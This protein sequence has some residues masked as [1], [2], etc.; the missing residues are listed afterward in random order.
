MFS[1]LALIIIDASSDEVMYTLSNP[2]IS[3]RFREDITAFLRGEKE[4]IHYLTDNENEHLHDVREHLRKGATLPASILLLSAVS[5]MLFIEKGA[6]SRDK[7]ISAFLRSSVIVVGLALASALF[8]TFFFELFHLLA[9]PQGNY[10]FPA[11]SML[12]I[13]MPESFFRNFFLISAALAAALNTGILALFLELEKRVRKK[14]PNQS[15]P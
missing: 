8:F 6:L 10:I 3:E 11:Y 14:G 12:I 7:I 4:S 1:S 13:S 5:I 2:G 15:N 9:F